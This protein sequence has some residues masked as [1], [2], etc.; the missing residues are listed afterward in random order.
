VEDAKMQT[1]MDAPLSRRDLFKAGGKVATGVAAAGALGQ[2]AGLP[3]VLASSSRSSTTLNF[4]TGLAGPDG[5][6][7]QAIVKQFNQ[8]HPDITVK[9]QIIGT[10]AQF[11][12][13]LLPALTAGTAPEVFTTHVQEM[14]Y[15]QANGLF[16]KIDDLFGPSLPESDFAAQ[17]MQYV[18]YQG[19][20]YGM[21]LDMHGWGFYF[22]PK[23]L[24]QAGLPLRTPSSGEELVQWARKLTI[25][26]NGNN[27]L[28]KNFDG[29]SV[30]VYGLAS[31]WELPTLLQTI[32]S[33]G[34][35]TLSAD[36]R[37][38]LFNTAPVRDA[39]N[40][41]SDLIFKYHAVAKPAFYGA[42]GVW[43]AAYAKSQVA[44]VPD[45]DWM[46]N[47]FPAHKNVSVKAV[48]MP[49]FGA[50]QVAW[51]SGHVIAAPASL[52]S[53]KKQAVYTFMRYLS[54]QGVAWTKG[55]GH[56]PARTSQRKSLSVTSLFPQSTYAP[57]LAEIG[58]IEQP[59]KV[60]F[61]VQ[62]GYDPQMTAMLNGTKSV[63][64]ALAAAQSTVTRALSRA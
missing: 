8:M 32:W 11:Y 62:D 58:R 44:M 55:A 17:P 23:L 27:G 28:S 31:S 10:W 52:P 37:T 14:L 12:S 22:N 6:T 54:S 46:R 34:G 33:F 24:Q 3:T 16:A 47:W 18:K 39:F 15:F 50:K 1:P 64:A 35:N 21:P 49:K 57:E 26:K 38:A 41:W 61:D 48:F 51:M 60:F 59:S 63:S 7:M 20:I 29:N 40:Y 42:I 30:K 13:K 56:I 9:M 19:S 43:D 53:E 25:D 2:I 4:L 36:G 45:G 5:Q